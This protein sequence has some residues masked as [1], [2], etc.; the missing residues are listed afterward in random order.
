MSTQFA[1][2]LRLA[3][4]K[5][6][7]TQSDIAH[8]LNCH[9]TVVSAL[10]HGRQRPSLEQIVELSLV[11]GRSFEAF[12]AE[13]VSERKTHLRARI[14]SLP[15]HLQPTAMTFNREGSLARLQQRLNDQADHE[16]A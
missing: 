13:L 7:Y 12:F 14:A 4:R 1:L 6:G 5:S 10:E 9:Q 11:Y 8:L 3:R 15:A 16:G 2:D